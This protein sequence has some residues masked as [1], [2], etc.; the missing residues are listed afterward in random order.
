MDH[1]CEETVLD[2]LRA[3]DIQPACSRPNV[4]HFAGQEIQSLCLGMSARAV[5]LTAR[6]EELGSVYT[7]LSKWL[8]QD[9]RWCDFE[10][11]S[12]TIN[13]NHDAAA[14]R[15]IGN[16]GPSI[17]RIVGDFVGGHLF[18]F[19]LDDG[20]SNP[21]ELPMHEAELLDTSDFVLFDGNQA[22]GVFPFEGE[23]YSVIYFTTQ[24]A[25]CP[26]AEGLVQDLRWRQG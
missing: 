19:P 9:P 17:A 6:T 14:H 26:E 10:F 2:V 13:K 20:L 25:L 12:I 18:H 1:V 5:K 21:V 11:T 4:A 15:D 24:T 8:L 22:H 16:A 3:L 7:L 23:R